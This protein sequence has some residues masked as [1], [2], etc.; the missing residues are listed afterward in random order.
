MFTCHSCVK[1]KYPLAFEKLHDDLEKIIISPVNQSSSPIKP[2]TPLTPLAPSSPLD[3]LS[4]S[5]LPYSPHS[6]SSIQFLHSNYTTPTHIPH[7]PLIPN[8][9]PRTMRKRNHVNSI[10][11]VKKVL[12]VVII[13]IHPCASN[14]LKED[15][16]GVQKALHV[17][18]HIQSYAAHHLSLESVIV[19]AVIFIT[20]VVQLG[21]I[22]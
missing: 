1:S 11:M 16:R 21:L 9:C 22:I 7:P 13:P 8:S 15:Q 18:L 6:F 19:I 3:Y 10:C 17:N 12:P 20:L 5:P 4:N 14:T 2:T